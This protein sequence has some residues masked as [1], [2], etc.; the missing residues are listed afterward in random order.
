METTGKRILVIDDDAKHLM[1]VKEILET[2]GHDVYTHNKPFGSTQLA[3]TLEPDLI[4]L[5]VNMPGLSGDTLARL[6]RSHSEAP[7]VFYSS[8]DEDSLRQMVR[9]H[10]VNGYICKGD[11]YGLR[12]KVADYL[13]Q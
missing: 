2:E 4:L 6:L 8:N 3:R 11:L 5:D 12:V 9:F 10:K 13:A 1:T 7:I